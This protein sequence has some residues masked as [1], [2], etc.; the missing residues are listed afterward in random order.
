MIEM[1]YEVVR[2]DGDGWTMAASFYLARACTV[3]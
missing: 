2:D 3:R 1:R